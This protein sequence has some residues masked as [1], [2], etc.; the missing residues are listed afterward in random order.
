MEEEC[1]NTYEPRFLNLGI[2]ALWLDDSLLL[3]AVCIVECLAAYLLS[4][5]QMER[6]NT[7]LSLSDSQKCHQ[8]CPSVSPDRHNAPS[9]EPIPYT[10]FKKPSPCGRVAQLVKRPTLAQVTI[11]RSMSSSPAAGSVLTPRS[12]EPVSDSVSPSLSDP[13]LFMLC[14]SL[15]QK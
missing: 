13:L 7:P 15:S 14:L 8:T 2:I 6:I 5:H 10:Q 9:W 4:I 12:L 11:S 1:V 3:G